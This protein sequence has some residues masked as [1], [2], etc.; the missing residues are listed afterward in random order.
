M[1]AILVVVA[2]IVVVLVIWGWYTEKHIWKLGKMMS[3]TQEGINS[4]DSQQQWSPVVHLPLLCYFRHRHVVLGYCILP[5]GGWGGGEKLDHQGPRI[6]LGWDLGHKGSWYLFSC[7]LDFPH[8]K[9]GCPCCRIAINYRILD[10]RA[11]TNPIL[12]YLL[13]TNPEAITWASL[14]E[15]QGWEGAVGLLPACQL[16]V[17]HP[18]LPSPGFPA[19]PYQPGVRK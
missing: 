19:R 8:W 14:G 6:P 12:S 10:P 9:F 4:K 1:L 15:C 11:G 2:V 5:L 16:F 18:S 13:H 3:L 7:P 17:T